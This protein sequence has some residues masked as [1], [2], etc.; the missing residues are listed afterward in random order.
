M[1]RPTAVA[2][3][4]ANAPAAGNRTVVLQFGP[5]I[6]T[7]GGMA[8]VLE[9]YARLPLSRVRFE[10][11][12]TWTPDAFAWGARLLAGA[13]RRLQ[14]S[15][16]STTIA[17]VHL[18]VRGSF[19][20]EGLLVAL[21]RRRGIPV[22]VSLHGGKL[23]EFGE[24]HPRLVG[25]V[26]SAADAVI[27]LGPTTEEL[28]RRYASPGTRIVVVPNPIEIPA[29][30]RPAGDL[31][32]VAL[33]AGEVG[34]PKGADVLIDAWP[35]VHAACPSARL[36]IAGPPGDV[37]PAPFED[38]EWT[39]ALSRAEVG[40]RLVQS[41]VAVL[42]SRNEVMPMFLLEAMAA[43]RPIV[44][45]PVGEM[46]SLVGEAGLL[47]PPGEADAL[48]DALILLLTD[49]TESTRRGT[50]L[51]RR[52][53][54]RFSPTR[55]AAELEAVYESV[56][57][58]LGRTDARAHGHSS[59]D[60]TV[61]VCAFNAAAT[62]DGALASVAGQTMAPG[63]V[64]VVDD[65][66]SDNTAAL[67]LAWRNQ[68]PIDVVKLDPNVGI[69]EARRQAVARATTPLIAILDADDVLLPDHLETML[70]VYRRAPGIVTAHA[71]VWVP[72]KGIGPAN[73][74]TRYVPPPDGQ[75]RRLLDHDFLSV[76]TLFARSDCERAGGFRK[77]RAAEDW[78]L[79]LRMVRNGVLVSRAGHPTV[80]YRIGANSISF[81]YRATTSDAYVLELAV[82][83]AVTDDERRWARQSLRRFEAKG[84]LAKAYEHACDGQ[85]GRARASAL[86]ALRYGTKR[87]RLRAAVIA[88]APRA[89]ARIH[90]QRTPDLGRWIH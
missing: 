61:T 5:A 34:R 88:L 80:M 73:E 74:A 81:G 8:S 28:A 15:E 49:P 1:H 79:W 64:V 2:R 7:Q 62:I 67:A 82:R 51:R 89:A 46:P 47:V 90:E 65:G 26:L 55:V 33:F 11:V 45:T 10:F 78:D 68:L 43:A 84:A 75:L 6:G 76:T 19:V 13:A 37:E 20:R 71:L 17:H 9:S 39:G 77:L 4:P 48:A 36:I 16:T 23:L 30:V 44:T 50:A 69:G 66:S 35:R 14:R 53:E 85:N 18:S 57:P 31:P 32:P 24:R 41:R 21:A 58:A 72:G 70:D 38:V 56:A 40:A 27:A 86:R 12:P 22:V 3:A 42:P 60:I 54:E 83:E 59:A 63:A 52:A 29:D 25:R 87:V